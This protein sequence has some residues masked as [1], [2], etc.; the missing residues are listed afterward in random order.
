MNTK[1]Y[2]GWTNYETWL[3]NLWLGESEWSQDCIAEMVKSSASI[4]EVSDKIKDYVYDTEV[5][6][7]TCCLASDLL[8]GA[9]S[10]VNWYELAEAWREDYKEED[11][12][13]NS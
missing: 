7:D 6:T 11:E 4:S 5:D 1:E 12:D 10:E 3:V 9:L 13:D 2:N 8:N